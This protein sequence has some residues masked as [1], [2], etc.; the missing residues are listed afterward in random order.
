MP[1][2][3]GYSNYDGLGLAER[4]RRI[5]VHPSLRL[6]ISEA[7][8]NRFPGTVAIDFGPPGRISHLQM[9][10]LHRPAVVSV[11]L[12]LHLSCFPDIGHQHKIPG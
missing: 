12:P 11:E 4:Q 2:V 5:Q 3:S 1:N 6:G 10:F 7:N 8:N 9:T